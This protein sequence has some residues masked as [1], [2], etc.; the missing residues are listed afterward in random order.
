MQHFCVKNRRLKLASVTLPR[1]RRRSCKQE[2][3][4]S[5][6]IWWTK[7]NLGRLFFS[8][9]LHNESSLFQ[10]EGG[11]GVSC[12]LLRVF[13]P[14]TSQLLLSIIVELSCNGNSRKHDIHYFFYQSCFLSSRRRFWRPATTLPSN[15]CFTMNLLWPEHGSC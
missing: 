12:Q 4:R 15:G 14:S 9:I 5:N 3:K 6:T 8:K 13:F 11:R 1:E 7:T 10:G 2:P